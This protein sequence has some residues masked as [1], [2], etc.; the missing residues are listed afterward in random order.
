MVPRKRSK[1]RK[2]VLVP[3]MKTAAKIQK[4]IEVAQTPTSADDSIFLPIEAAD[5]QPE[6]TSDDESA[7]NGDVEAFFVKTFNA[8]ADG[9][10]KYCVA[11][12]FRERTL[13]DENKWEHDFIRMHWK[14]TLSDMQYEHPADCGMLNGVHDG[15]YV[16]QQFSVSEYPESYLT[17][18]RWKGNRNLGDSSSDSEWVYEY[19]KVYNITSDTFPGHSMIFIAWRTYQFSLFSFYQRLSIGSFNAKIENGYVNNLMFASCMIVL[20]ICY[21]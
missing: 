2:K 4:S 10:R 7:S 3:L 19:G 15:K 16:R 11:T 21:R 9:I 14:V 13:N 20:L 17:W 6:L 5:E 18:I 12:S 8:Y 1:A